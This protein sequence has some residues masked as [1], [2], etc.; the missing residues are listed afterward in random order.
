MEEQKKKP[1]RPKGS[2]NPVV[3]QSVKQAAP[4]VVRPKAELVEPVGSVSARRPTIDK[5]EDIWVVSQF[6]GELHYVSKRTGYEVVWPELGAGEYVSFEE[7]TSMANSQKKFFVRN[8]IAM[9]PAVLCALRM[10]KYYV[11]SM[12]LDEY[13]SVFDVPI[14]QMEERLSVLPEGQ[15]MTLGYRA[16]MLFYEG[17]IDSRQRIQAIQRALDI[18]LSE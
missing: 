10:D 4:S 6:P 8:W 12:S 15:K 2:V 17:K 11:N 1:G 13:E 14:P 7:L 16:R 3:E 18:E 5:N 9:D